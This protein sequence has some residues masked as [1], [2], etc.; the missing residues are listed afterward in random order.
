MPKA[1]Y[2]LLLTLVLLVIGTA[3]LKTNLLGYITLAGIVF[4]HSGA[5]PLRPTPDDRLCRRHPNPYLRYLLYRGAITVS[6]A[7]LLRSGWSGFTTIG[8]G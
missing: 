7:A 2:S 4:R 6:D 1:V 3:V 5:A 8:S